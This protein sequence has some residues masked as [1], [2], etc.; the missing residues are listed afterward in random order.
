DALAPGGQNVAGSG[1]TAF[2]WRMLMASERPPDPRPP[3]E[4]MPPA[5]EAPPAGPTPNADERL[6]AMFAHLFALA[7]YFVPFGNVIGPLV[8]WLVKKDSS[9]F[10]DYHGK[11]SLNFQINII[12]YVAISIPL[13]F[14][15]IGIF[16]MIAAGIYGL[17]MI[18]IAAIKANS[19][20]Y[21][22]YPFTFRIVT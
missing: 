21:Y 10:V 18:I 7:G 8:V 9:R 14:C 4:V 13:I 1:L 20:E 16:T 5:G 6:W 12:L 22:R 3:E 15:V 2:L 19:G 11:E 17:I